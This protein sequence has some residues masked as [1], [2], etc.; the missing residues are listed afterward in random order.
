MAGFEASA[1]ITAAISIFIDPTSF[2][3]FSIT[4]TLQFRAWALCFSGRFGWD[5]KFCIAGNCKRQGDPDLTPTDFS[6]PL[7]PLNPGF[8]LET[9]RPANPTQYK[10]LA[11]YVDVQ[12]FPSVAATDS[13]LGVRTEL[14]FALPIVCLNV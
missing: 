2:G 5:K 4:V 13:A 9:P 6:I 8:F 1:E 14:H 10:I 7:K 3:G 12:S 11:D